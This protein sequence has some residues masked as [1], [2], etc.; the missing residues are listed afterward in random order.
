MSELAS[1][2]NYVA[3]SILAWLAVAQTHAGSD[4]HEFRFVPDGN[5]YYVLRGTP[6]IIERS[7]MFFAVRSERGSTPP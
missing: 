2:K 3:R 7:P 1:L 5:A 6:V 4:D